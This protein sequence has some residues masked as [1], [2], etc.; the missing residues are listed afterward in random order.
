MRYKI[1]G[2][3]VK[4]K[5]GG[6]KLGMSIWIRKSGSLRG[7]SRSELRKQR[8]F[9]RGDEDGGKNSPACNSG[10]GTSKLHPSPRIP[11]IRLYIVIYILLLLVLNVDSFS[12]KK[13]VLKS[14]SI[15]IIFSSDWKEFWLF[16]SLSLP[17][18]NFKLPT[19]EKWLPDY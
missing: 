14:Q 18:S 13:R 7:L 19:L 5:S 16:T 17:S 3:S 6:N 1:G 10:R 15:S 11:Q 12:K 4:K 9:S 2:N 8:F